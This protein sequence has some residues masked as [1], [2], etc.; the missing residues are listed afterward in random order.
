M[1]ET[2]SPSG[3]VGTALTRFTAGEAATGTFGTMDRNNITTISDRIRYLADTG[4]YAPASGTTAV[5][6]LTCT[7]VVGSSTARFTGVGIGLSPVYAF[8]V[9]QSNAGGGISMR[10]S[11]TDS[12]VGTNTEVQFVRN[13]STVGS[14]TTTLAGVTAYNTSSDERLKTWQALGDV[15]HLIDGVEVVD[16]AFLK[17]PGVRW[18]MLR[19][20]QAH[21][22]VPWAVVVGGD[23]P[24]VKPWTMDY[25][26]LV[27]LHHRELQ[28]LRARVAK[29][30]GRAD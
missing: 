30:E 22:V 28:A 18:P 13:G 25:S 19:A 20:Q 6:A 24:A 5:Q 3:M 14:I 11:D 4:L 17:E 23:D 2:Y 15:G 9:S 27:P 10:L 7:T 29:L 21:R 8:D 12:A 16:G 26:K 1:S